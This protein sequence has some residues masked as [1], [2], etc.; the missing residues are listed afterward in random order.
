MLSSLFL[1]AAVSSVQAAR[2]CSLLQ[3]QLVRQEVVLVQCLWLMDAPLLVVE[4][5]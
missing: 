2:A 3:R 1:L 4:K 5:M